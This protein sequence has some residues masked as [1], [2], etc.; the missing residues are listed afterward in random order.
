MDYN[1]YEGYS[2]IFKYKKEDSLMDAAQI[3][4]E[5]REDKIL[6]DIDIKLKDRTISAHRIILAGSIPHFYDMFCTD[7]RNSKKKTI[8]MKEYDSDVVEALVNYW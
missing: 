7:H 4:Q 8:I 5:L 3:F 1:C 6:C 2:D